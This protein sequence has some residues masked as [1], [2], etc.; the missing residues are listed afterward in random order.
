MKNCPNCGEQVKTEAIVCRYCRESIPAATD[1]L[2]ARR[3]GFSVFKAI[4]NVGLGGTAIVFTFYD[5]KEM[6]EQGLFWSLINPFFHV[7]V[8]FLVF[9]EPFF[10]YASGLAIIGLIG[11]Y[12]CDFEE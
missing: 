5:I 8:F 7:K 10:W 1:P 12:F 3:F 2:R 11:V 6:I 4:F 9:T